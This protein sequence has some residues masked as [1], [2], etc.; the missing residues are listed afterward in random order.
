MGTFSL[1]TTTHHSLGPSGSEG[2]EE[3]TWGVLKGVHRE[4]SV[5]KFEEDWRGLAAQ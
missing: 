1:P 3:I 5:G 4:P 2:G